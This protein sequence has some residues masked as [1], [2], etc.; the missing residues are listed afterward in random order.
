MAKMELG[1][2]SL[3]ELK[4]LRKKVDKAIN[5]FERRQK[6]EALAKLEAQAKQMGYSLAEL[7]GL[8]GQKG[9]K[10][11]SPPKYRDPANSANTWTGRGRQP[12]WFKS[13]LKAGKKPEDMLIA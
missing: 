10:T 4:D 8:K 7:A 3:K 13:A 5:D 12:E 11:A 6:A 2:M 9:R 1:K